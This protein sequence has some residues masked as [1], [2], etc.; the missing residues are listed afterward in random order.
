MFLKFLLIFFY[1]AFICN[2]ITAQNIVINHGFEEYWKP[3]IYPIVTDTFYIKDWS[4]IYLSYPSH[5][6][7]YL[8]G[9]FQKYSEEKIFR[10]FNVPDNDFGY[11]PAHSGNAYAGIIPYSMKGYME[12][13]TGKLS[14]PLIK[15]KKYKISFYIKYAGNKCALYFTKLEM[16]FASDSSLFK[17]KQ[18]LQYYFSE[19]ESTYQNIFTKQKVY[20]DV[21][22]D[23]IP[24]LYDTSYWRKLT[25]IYI[26][27]GGEKY[28]TIGLF[29]QGDEITSRM[30][31]MAIEYESADKPKKRKQLFKNI[32]KFNIPFIKYNPNYNIENFI[33][34]EGKTKKLLPQCDF[35][36]YFIDDVSV[37]LAEDSI[38]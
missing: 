26:A 28:F 14:I 12:Y 8:K 2:N 27:K 22:F 4:N 32:D 24:L 19:K 21:I 5:V 29:Y 18:K 37:E 23:N 1:F 36:Y 13:L 35:G 7:F 34:K 38:K 16:S 17:T 6:D 15:D 11:H 10:M 30:N 9:N 31:K 20:M 25:N 3:Q 33:F